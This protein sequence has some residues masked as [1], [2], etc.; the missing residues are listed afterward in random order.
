MEKQKNIE[1]PDKKEG[2]FEETPKAQEKFKDIKSPEQEIDEIN[3]QIS[4]TGELMEKEKKELTES[5]AKLGIPGKDEESVSIKSYKE[6]I[7]SLTAR[8]KDLEKSA[9]IADKTKS[10]E[11]N[12]REKEEVKAEKIKPQEF[13]DF[14]KAVEG[15]VIVLRERD[16]QRLDQLT[17]DP[18]KIAG[19]I[20]A[21]R[22][23]LSSKNPDTDGVARAIGRIANFI[24]ELG[25]QQTRT[26][27]KENP[28]SLGKLAHF[29]VK[30]DQERQALGGRINKKENASDI[31]SSLN[32]IKSAVENKKAGIDRKLAF[33]RQ[34]G[35]R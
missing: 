35:G 34:L 3:K 29:L 12:K 18:G 25:E 21:I 27:I 31:L 10:G 20:S 23:A 1:T 11:E 7:N 30:I 16:S 6:K 9:G 17:E 19:A 8:K 13:E 33:F 4:E 26:A 5:R 2:V 22:S 24:G 14:I 15:M 28:D 32:R